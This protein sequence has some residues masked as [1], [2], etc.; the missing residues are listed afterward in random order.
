MN[1]KLGKNND[2]WAIILE[3]AWA[4]MIGNYLHFTYGGFL[5]NGLSNLLGY[6][7]FSYKID[8]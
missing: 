1:A 5:E 3:K 7:V 8:Y 4:K 6:P 2:F